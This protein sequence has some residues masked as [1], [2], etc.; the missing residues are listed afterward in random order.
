M[1]IERTVTESLSL[2]FRALCLLLFDPL[3]DD[4]LP[5]LLFLLIAGLNFDPDLFFFFSSFFDSCFCSCSSS[6]SVSSYIDPTYSYI[7]ADILCHQLRMFFLFICLWCLVLYLLWTSAA[8]S[9]VY[10]WC[11]STRTIKKFLWIM[12]MQLPR[13]FN[14]GNWLKGEHTT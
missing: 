8:F 4:S 14:T 9:S 11:L 2:S 3:S 13:I 12:P 10:Q 1:A 5:P 6:L 7:E